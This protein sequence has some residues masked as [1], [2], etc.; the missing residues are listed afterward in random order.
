MGKHQIAVIV[1][2]LRRESFNRKLAD[3]MAKLAPSAFSFKQL[4]IGDLPLYNQS[5]DVN[6]AESVKRLKSD[7]RAKEGLFDAA[8]TLAWT[9]TFLQSWMKQYRVWNAP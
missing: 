7:I 5:D 1:G 3:A 2:S 8:A 9:A 4:Q 6:Q